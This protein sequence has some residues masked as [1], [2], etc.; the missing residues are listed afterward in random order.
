ML[1]DIFRK[2]LSYTNVE[3]VDGAFAGSYIKAIK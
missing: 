1:L 2:D 3:Q